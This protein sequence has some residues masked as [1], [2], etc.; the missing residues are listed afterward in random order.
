MRGP[1][2]AVSTGILAL[3]LVAWG[4]AHAQLAGPDTAIVRFEVGAG[5][6]VTNEQFY[7]DAFIDTIALGRRLV[8]SPETYVTSI[9]HVAAVGSRDSRATGYRLDGEAAIGN[10]VQRGE[11]S[12]GWDRAASREWRWS[13]APDAEYR[14]DQSF[15][16]DLEEARATALGRVIRLL[17][18]ISSRFELAGRGEWLRTRGVGADFIPDRN[19]A[20]LA[21]S[22]ERTPLIGPE[23]GVRYGATAR[24]FPDS[25]TRDHLEQTVELSGRND[26]AGGHALGGELD[27][28]RR[29]TFR[30]APTSRDNYW[31]ADAQGSVTMFQASGVGL[32]L[33]TTAE[34][35]RYDAP[36]SAVF[37]DYDLARAQLSP[38]WIT[39]GWT[40]RLGPRGELLRS[41]HD[42]S[43]QYREL[44]GVLEI[45]WA[46]RR[47]WW[48][49]TPIAGWRDYTGDAAAD[50]ATAAVGTLPTPSTRSSY[51]FY[52]LDGVVEQS[53]WG[54]LTFRAYGSGRIERHTDSSQ[55]A[56]SLY[57]SCEVRRLF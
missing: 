3:V 47:G 8:S 6:G 34:S 56:R 51:A 7:E 10:R 22:F 46:P 38:Q 50:V 12:L 45:E 33:A 18:R 31:E 20:G 14:R 23:W 35:M 25:T 11:L 36:D 39:T 48:T 21:A 53:F 9:L 27:V 52:E 28:T 44:A 19:A 2:L 49:L 16:R 54:G 1:P 15:G 37:F 29:S 57:I 41:P 13:L 43:E 42:P 55:D 40:F 32:V 4:P 17:P 5:S 26:V 30:S 24:Q